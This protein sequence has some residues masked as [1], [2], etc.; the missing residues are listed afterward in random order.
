MPLDFRHIYGNN[1]TNA[2]F[3]S[4]NGNGYAIK[5]DQL[6]KG[7]QSPLLTPFKKIEVRLTINPVT[8]NSQKSTSQK[9]DV[10]HIYGYNNNREVV[11]TN[12]VTQ[13]SITAQKE[14]SELKFYLK[15]IEI[16]Y[17]EVRLNAFPY[18]GSQCYNFGISKISI[19]GWP[20]D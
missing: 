2:N 13:G 6:Y 8:N 15:N 4:N 5:F 12:Y 16:T 10:L 14:N 18:K 17:F 9:D 7:I 19:K 20:Y 11:E 1:F 3:Y